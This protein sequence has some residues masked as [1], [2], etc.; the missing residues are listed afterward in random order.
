MDDALKFTAEGGVAPR[1][2]LDPPAGDR[3]RLRFEV[4]GTG[5]IP[6]RQHLPARR[7]PRHHDPAGHGRPAE[8]TRAIRR[9]E[10][11]RQR[12]TPIVALTAHAMEA[13]RKTSLDNGMDEQITR[14]LTMATLTDR[15]LE[16]LAAAEAREA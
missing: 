12:R 11:L 6:R 10:E 8:A 4:A 9:I 2:G 3:F 1:A 13:S 15:L 7:M 5:I 14:P 16:W